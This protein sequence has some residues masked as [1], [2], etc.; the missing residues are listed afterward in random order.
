MKN[1]IIAVLTAST[2]W[3]LAL[4]L[5]DRGLGKENDKEL[6]EEAISALSGSPIY[7]D[8]IS[9]TVNGNSYMMHK[10]YN[11]YL[12]AL[13]GC[14]GGIACASGNAL[15]ISNIFRR[16]PESVQSGI[17]AHESGHMING[18]RV[19]KMLQF[20]RAFGGQE[21]LKLEIEA[22][23][24]ASAIVGK[25]VMLDTLRYLLTLPLVSKKEIHKR[26][27]TLEKEA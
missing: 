16:M 6:L 9:V 11:P 24:T 5:R 20:N 21:S 14:T 2:I 3:S 22:D 8:K 1:L 19:T 13:L 12:L 26:I 27:H 25:D 17:I 10:I 15:I 23:R 18:H 7:G 4:I